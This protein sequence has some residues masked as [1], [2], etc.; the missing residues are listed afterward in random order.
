MKRIKDERIR[1]IAPY[2]KNKIVLDIGCYAEIKEDI[3]KE[4]KAHWIHGFLS[5][6]AKHAI[7]IDIAKKEIDILKKQGYDVYCQ[8]AEN[9]SFNRKFD[10]I[11]AGA[12]I[13]HLSNPGL[14]LDR[15]RKHLKKDGWLIVD[16][17]N[18]FCLNYKIGGMIRFLNNDLEV[19]PEHTC[20]FSP[21]VMKNLMKRH[22]FVVKRI[23]FVN[24]HEINTFK[25]SL[26]DFLCKIFGDKLRYEMMLFAQLTL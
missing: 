1:E 2:I 11:F 8:N 4:K 10:V 21:T 12:V 6:N 26:Q 20:F 24:F 15:C 3:N 17:Y 13:E 18:V 23:K 25:R 9:F 14:F 19:H 16:T 5:E 7:G 22:G